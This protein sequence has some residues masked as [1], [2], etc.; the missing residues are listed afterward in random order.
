[1]GVRRVDDVTVPMHDSLEAAERAIIYDLV[2]YHI[3]NAEGLIIWKMGLVPQ[4]STPVPGYGWK[5]SSAPPEECKRRFGGRGW[6][7]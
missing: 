3:M 6:V 5:A 7:P 4:E 1:M 2:H